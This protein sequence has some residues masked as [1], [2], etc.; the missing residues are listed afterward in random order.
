[1]A[2]A[3]SGKELAEELQAA[4]RSRALHTPMEQIIEAAASNVLTEDHCFRLIGQLWAM[5]RMYYYVYGA[6]GSSLTI[7]QYPP[8]VDYLFA[9]QVYDESTHEMLY[10]QAMLQKG[11]AKFQRSALRHPYC[12]FVAA[13]GIGLYIFS[14][15]GLANYAHSLRMA[16]IDL[17]PKVLE[18][19][20]L[21]RL[22]GAIQDAY[23]QK[24]FASQLPETRSHVMMGRFMV[25]R[26][27]SQ[28]VD[29]ELCQELVS[30]AHRDYT[31]AL[32]GIADF[33]LTSAG[34]PP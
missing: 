10:S 27:V 11:W 8:S 9:K 14:M 29:V 32:Q 28:P 3:L 18:L 33:V 13:S 30:M 7:N 5:K 34:N 4:S 15:R 26:F 20:W 1:M 17:G 21:E 19:G 2:T 24:L 12:Q 31:T 16:A 22:A 6:W 23:L 25:E